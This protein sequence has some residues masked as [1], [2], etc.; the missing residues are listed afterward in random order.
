MLALKFLRHSLCINPSSNLG[1]TISSRPHSQRFYKL[2]KESEALTSET[3]T[4][5]AAAIPTT[6]STSAKKPRTTPGTSGG[7]KRKQAP[8]TATRAATPVESGATN[9]NGDGDGDDQADAGENDD[10][11]DESPSKKPKTTTKAKGKPR[12]KPTATPK[13]KS[14]AVVAAEEEAVDDADMG[15]AGDG[16]ALV[17]AEDR[18]GVVVKGEANEDAEKA[19][20]G[21]IAAAAEDGAVASK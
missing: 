15:E 12:A 14:T 2:K 7:R 17:K 5:T 20:V 21:S 18:V 11:R 19:P 6:P 10:D 8:I 1:L 9:G 4:A 13:K 16:N 3:A